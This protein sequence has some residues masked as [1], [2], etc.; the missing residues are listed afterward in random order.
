VE[1]FVEEELTDVEELDD[2]ETGIGL[3]ITTANPVIT[4]T[5]T[6]ETSIISIRA[7]VHHRYYEGEAVIMLIYRTDWNSTAV[8]SSSNAVQFFR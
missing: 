2:F 3:R 8:D 7:I 4:A 1:I 5:T 6:T